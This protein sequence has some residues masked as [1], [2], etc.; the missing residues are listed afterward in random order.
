M[1]KKYIKRKIYLKKISPFVDKDIIK[2][3]VG[4]RRVG[5]S[6]L[7]FQIMDLIKSK[8]KNAH[9]IYINKELN[10][11]DKIKGYQD[12]LDYIKKHIRQNVKKNYIF[13][14]EIQDIDKF[15]KALRSLKAEGGYDIYCTGSNANLL[16]GELA[17][18]LS[19]RYI[20]IKVFGLSYLEFLEFH[21]LKNNK[22][23]LL[24]YI[25]YGGLPY[26]INLDLK[27]EVVYGYLK[28]IYSTILLKDIVDRYKI[29]NI[30]FLE[31]LVE[32]LAD[33][34]GSLVSAKKISDFLKSQK[35]N[36][37]P[38]IVLDYLSFLSNAFFIF[39]V[40]R[41]NIQGKKVFEINDKYY[42]EDLGLRHSVIGY[43]QPD[44][45][46]ILENLVFLHLQILGYKI[47]VGQLKNKEID[48]VCEKQNKKIYIQVAYIIT[49]EN[50]EREFGNLL[51][52]QDNFPKIVVSMDEMISEES[53][54][55]IKHIN[56][57][58]FLSNF[59]LK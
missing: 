52:I 6:Y 5:K 15:E 30:P 16:S 55:G 58:D 44:I 50:K 23:S 8:H 25:K 33:N 14:D 56:I 26:L 3:I 36:I 31:N 18:Y 27:D 46:K 42:F 28:S 41:S 7:L 49:D 48:F 19:G 54:K 43:K 13:I 1:I 17:T 47:T 45:N 39:K 29:R 24:Q 34:V 2:V 57:R 38:N 11:F 22:D 12:L 21:K 53:Y 40:P 32:Y 35:I 9:I 59:M 51:E 37:S 10:E 20:E 4:Q